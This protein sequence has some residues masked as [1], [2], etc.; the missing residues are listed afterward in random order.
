MGGVRKTLRRKGGGKAIEMSERQNAVM[1]RLTW[2]EGREL[3]NC[4]THTPV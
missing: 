2:K 1:D 3:C 4:T